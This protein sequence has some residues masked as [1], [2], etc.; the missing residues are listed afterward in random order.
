MQWNTSIHD[1]LA[2]RGGQKLKLI[3]MIRDASNELFARFVLEDSTAEHMRVWQYLE[4]NGQPLS[5]YTDKAALFHVPPR[6]IS[7][8][9]D[10][11]RALR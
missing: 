4:R 11:T 2:G 10:E 3:A 7:D 8:N 5:F 1:W 9:G 6:T